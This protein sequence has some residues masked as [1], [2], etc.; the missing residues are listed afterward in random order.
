M[1]QPRI[2]ERVVTLT[3]AGGAAPTAR[4]W[5]AS[6]GEA[7]KNMVITISSRNEVWAAGNLTWT[8]YYGGYWSVGEPFIIG[9]THAG[10]VSKGTNVIGGGTAVYSQ[11]HT[12]VGPFLPN[13]IIPH[14]GGNHSLD[15]GRNGVP[16]VVELTNA[17]AVALT[18]YI[19]FQ[20]ETVVDF[21]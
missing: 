17:K 19:T 14:P 6:E 2:T 5:D 10:G 15:K 4:C 1:G 11:I 7:F 9:S 8:V 13:R 18:V 16:I 3:A 12:D 20:S 21:R